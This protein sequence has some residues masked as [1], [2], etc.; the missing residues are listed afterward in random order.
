M[1]NAFGKS[2]TAFRLESMIKVSEFK[3]V[4]QRDG[5]DK[6]RR[7]LTPSVRFAL[8]DVRAGP[9]MTFQRR[10]V[11]LT[12][13]QKK[14]MSE[15]K[16]KLQASPTAGGKAISADNEAAARQKFIQISLGMIYDEHHKAHVID[17]KPRYAELYDIIELTQRK[18][19]VFVV[20]TAAIHLM[21]DYVRKQA[22]R[23]W[24]GSA[25]TSTVKYRPRSGRGSSSRSSRMKTSR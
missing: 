2:F 15:L 11:Q 25:T 12:P 4:P 24:D 21:M 7:L 14:A 3:W 23:S 13:A 19:V 8:D 18:V 22:R 17:A 6:A 10:R 9:P 20:I 5:Y 16:G 1:N